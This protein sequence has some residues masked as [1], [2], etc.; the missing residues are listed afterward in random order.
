MNTGKR[1]TAVFKTSPEVLFDE[2]SKFILFSDCHRGDNSWADDFAHNEHLYQYA[3]TRYFRTGYTYIEIGDGDEL[4]ENNRFEDIRNAHSSVF[5]LLRRFHE[6]GRLVLI[7]GN[8][9]KER[10]S[11]PRVAHTLYR[12]FDERSGRQVPLLEGITVREGVVLRHRETGMRIFL[13]HGHQGDLLSDQLWWLGKL[14]SRLLWRQLQLL[15]IRD[16]TR[17]AV[18]SVKRKR[19]ERRLMRWVRSRE[20]LMVTGHTH[21]PRFPEPGSLPYFNDGS[22]VHPR[23]ITGIEV[24]GGKMALIRWSMRAR[25][26]GTLRITRNVLAGPMRLLEYAFSIRDQ[27]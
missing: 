3:L 26:D 16:P 7:Y 25:E 13:V 18:N 5:K 19:V 6:E 4:W 17:P 11:A 15:G 22:C 21:R 14:L 1:L 10:K 12:Y 9:D 24:V 23:S 8:H 2:R 20:H 27:S